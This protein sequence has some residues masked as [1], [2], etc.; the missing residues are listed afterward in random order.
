LAKITVRIGPDIDCE[1]K[2]L[3]TRCGD[4]MREGA[5]GDFY[6]LLPGYLKVKRARRHILSLE[7][8]DGIL[9]DNIGTLLDATRHVLALNR[10]PI[11]EIPPGL[12]TL[13]LNEIFLSIVKGHPERESYENSLPGLVHSMSSAIKELKEGLLRPEDLEVGISAGRNPVFNLLHLMFKNYQERLEMDG[14]VDREDLFLNAARCL[15]DDRSGTSGKKRPRA[16]FTRYL[17]VLGFYDLNPLQMKLFRSIVRAV[18]EVEIVLPVT[19]EMMGNQLTS[20]FLDELVALGAE[21]AGWDGAAVKWERSRDPVVDIVELPDPLRESEYIAKA[22]KEEVLGGKNLEECDIVVNPFSAYDRMLRV[23]FDRFGVPVSGM[24]KQLLSSNP[25]IKILLSCLE[26]KS[27]GFERDAV[28][29]LLSSSYLVEGIWGGREKS[30]GSVLL[31]LV[32]LARV[33]SGLNEWLTKIEEFRDEIST[34]RLW[35]VGELV[36]SRDRLRSSFYRLKNR[37]E[38][39][40][41]LCDGVTR[42]L[43][44]LRAVPLTAT[45]SDFVGAIFR[46]AER[47]KIV[48]G[49]LSHND[50]EVAAGDLRAFSVFRECFACWNVMLTGNT[51]VELDGFIAL[52]NSILRTVTYGEHVSKGGGVIVIDP[53]EKRHHTSHLTIICGM[54]ENY[55]SGFVPGQEILGDEMRRV[56]NDRVGREALQ[57]STRKKEEEG[58]IFDILLRRSTDR[59]VLTYPSLDGGSR[60]VIRSRFIDNLLEDQR[61][62]YTR[63]SPACTVP[64]SADIY[65]RRDLVRNMVFNST[66]K[67]KSRLSKELE[68]MKP[69]LGSVFNRVKMERN[70][71]R[72]LSNAWNGQ[73]VAED[74]LKDL[75]DRFGGDFIYSPSFLSNYLACPFLFMV[76]NIWRL[77]GRDSVELG[78]SRT[79]RG[80]IVHRTLNLFFRRFLE[81]GEF[82]WDT[83]EENL[84]RLDELSGQVLEEYFRVEYLGPRHL[85]EI[86]GNAVR[87]ELVEFVQKDIE[88]SRELGATPALLEYS[89]LDEGE[90]TRLETSAGEV[91][92]GGRLDRVDSLRSP[93]GGYIVIDY[94]TGYT[95]TMKDTAG[96]KSVQIPLYIIGLEKKG[97]NVLLGFYYHIG[98]GKRKTMIGP[99]R[100]Q[101]APK[102]SRDGADWDTIRE[103]VVEKIGEMIKSIRGG[104]FRN[105]PDECP[106]F[107]D[108]KD[109]CRVDPSRRR[110]SWRRG[111]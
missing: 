76:N 13:L 27:R 35:D 109:L 34:G 2:K 108:L 85:F 98:E 47:L 6:L 61:T 105:T 4:M 66:S 29:K 110:R 48:E 38:E 3:L 75:E 52:I 68:E 55:L 53:L 93:D 111:N 7:G 86:E 59:L 8:V 26:A 40:L 71:E 63:I 18:E 57:S 19:P 25:A 11:R 1:E 96:G 28:L 99:G 30:P 101:L 73:I 46:L 84:R 107:C 45:P 50:V 14:F 37:P 64:E 87:K 67:V 104:N 70:R 16:R 100:E 42:F 74:I 69:I 58:L 31:D 97:Y 44:T 80:K 43:D 90:E 79:H 88:L 39:L 56:I 94:K 22:I 10:L 12:K 89:L 20:R 82:S 78:M 21:I 5:Y 95:P 33:S 81:E 9:G 15:E 92:I 36:Y 62:K 77:E 41:R 106:L 23:S 49:I 32:D 72:G 103:A 54:T 60:E 102:G 51:R 17:A 65:D 24:D 83:V 91:R